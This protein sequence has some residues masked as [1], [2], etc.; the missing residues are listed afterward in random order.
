MAM[1]SHPT[2][3]VRLTLPSRYYLDAAIYE[4]E[5]EAIF[6]RSWQYVGHRSQFRQAGDYLTRTICDESIFV[7]RDEDGAL[8][9]FYNVCRHRAHRLLRGQGRARRIVCPYHAWT[10][11]LRGE[12]L[13]A[14]KSEQVAGFDRS[15]ICL[16]PVQVEDFAG[17]IFVNLEPDAA[18][19]ANLVPDLAEDLR[20]RVPDL[21]TLE[22]AESK[23]A[24][25][26]EIRAN[27][28]VVV[29]NYLECYHCSHAHR[30]FVKL[31]EM[32][33]YQLETGK[34]WS[35]QF[36]AA[37][38]P[39][40]SAYE[41]GADAPVQT[42]AFWFLW[43]NT[44]LT[45]LPGER[46]LAVS[47]IVPLGLDRAAFAGQ[48]LGPGGARGP[49]ARESYVDSVLMPEDVRLC[50]SVQL[51][52]RSRSYDQGLFIVDAERSGIAEHAVHQFHE[53]VREALADCQDAD[54]TALG[55]DGHA[56]Q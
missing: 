42:G 4:R 39:R 48:R 52:L 2:P 20:E 8:R 16:A 34:L 6:Y 5:K 31:F 35:R 17:L 10:Y 33:E 7:I 55:L 30:D 37:V 12:L 56:D 3:E 49:E 13:A 18:P 26:L 36:G 41:F 43:P 23:G 1:A 27:W 54:G 28:K 24:G 29:D 9:G 25:L 50:E 44:T 19:L 40:N 51:G 15:S 46:N 22:P 11:G 38:N 53:L 47:P 45:L 14:R 21:E 32:S